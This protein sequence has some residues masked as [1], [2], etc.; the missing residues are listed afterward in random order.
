MDSQSFIQ[1]HKTKSLPE[2]ALLLSKHP[3]L[4]KEFIINQI[5]GLQKAQKKLPE[6]YA[7]NNIIYPATISIEQCSSEQTA[8]F[9][10]TTICNAEQR[11]SIKPESII[12]LTGGFGVDSYYFSKQFKEVTY[13]E[14]NL[15]LF[16]TV[17][18]NF[19]NLNA[20]NINCLNTTTEQF[21]ITNTQKF[22]IAYIDPSRRNENQKVFM[23]ADC[24]PNIVD[25]KE[26]ILQI[27][28]SILV[29]TSPILDIKQSILELE[30]ISH[31]WV[32]SIDNECKEVL[33][34]VGKEN[35]T[36]PEINT[37]NIIPLHGKIMSGLKQE[38]SFNY[39]KEEITIVEFS[40]PLSYI[41]E[42]NTSILKAGAFKSITKGY[43][44]K[45]IAQN[46]HLYTS[47]KLIIGFPGRSFKV[48]TVLPYQ[49]KAFKKLGIKKANI[50]CRNFIDSVA[51]IKK[52][53]NLT[54]GGNEYIFATTNCNEKP[55]LIVTNKA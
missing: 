12:D 22:D 8:I 51:Q 48:N 32:V 31:I 23:L 13:L 27:A 28:D 18:T 46:S 55:I 37:I 29:K 10:A 36:T 53:L 42:P 17:T 34:L 15:E 35:N 47:D 49:P 21:L 44:V 52:K 4:D 54:D 26:A 14:P 3:E 5:N 30:A 7:N 20:N 1:Q 38:F 50:T 39:S 11:R 9:K 45:K 16:E 33:Y 24:I 6:F 40:E 2:I 41:Y 25:L 19:K 43:D